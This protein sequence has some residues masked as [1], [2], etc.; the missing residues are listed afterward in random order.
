MTW[1]VLRSTSNIQYL[2]YLCTVYDKDKDTC[3]R[4]SPF[5][6]FFF[7][8][9]LQTKAPRDAYIWRQIHTLIRITPKHIHLFIITKALWIIH[10]LPFHMGRQ[11]ECK[12]YVFFFV[13][14]SRILHP[15]ES[16]S[17]THFLPYIFCIMSVFVCSPYIIPN[18][19][20]SSPSQ[21]ITRMKSKS[22]AWGISLS[23]AYR[24]DAVLRGFP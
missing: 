16:L 7:F 13:I 24:G 2:H 9:N 15:K 4:I 21:R 8:R 6:R 10:P 14:V 5:Q 19:S 11:E 22:R 17:H 18:F 1:S 23:H 20:P 3:P 12:G